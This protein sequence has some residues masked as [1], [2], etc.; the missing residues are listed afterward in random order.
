[1]SEFNRL[2]GVLAGDKNNFDAL[3]GM[4]RNLRAAG[5][6][7]ASNNYYAKALER[8]GARS[9]ASRREAILTEMGMN[10]LEVKE[11]KQAAGIFEKCLKEF[12][13][14][15]RKPAWMLGLGEAYATGEQKDKNKARKVLE[16]VIGEN[17]SS[18]I[19]SKARELLKTL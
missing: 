15:A 8:A 12:P 16:A 18:E 9:N 6:F 17:P 2:N 14:S 19:S 13:A 11:T 5:L 1:V 10:A 3:E 4:G 7:R